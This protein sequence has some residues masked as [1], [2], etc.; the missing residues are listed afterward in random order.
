M[1]IVDLPIEG[2]ITINKSTIHDS[3]DPRESNLDCYPGRI[4]LMELP[5][6][7]TWYPDI[8]ND[9]NGRVVENLN[10]LPLPHTTLLE[11]I[12]NYKFN[13]FMLMICRTL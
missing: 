10:A 11:T 8:N 13:N 5:T 2:P 6:S 12:T 7:N 4:F 3:S 1:L 9:I